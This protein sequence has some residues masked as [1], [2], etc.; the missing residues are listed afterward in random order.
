LL[1]VDYPLALCL[2]AVMKR[3]PWGS[4]YMFLCEV[5]LLDEVVNKLDHDLHTEQNFIQVDSAI[6]LNETTKKWYFSMLY[7]M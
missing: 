4:L 6:I 1:F 2:L 7:F 5:L 3:K